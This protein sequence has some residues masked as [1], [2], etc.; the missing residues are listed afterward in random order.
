M[1]VN[2]EGEVLICDR[3]NKYLKMFN[4][5]GTF[6]MIIGQGLLKDPNRVCVLKQTN[7][8]LVN[9]NMMRCIKLFHKD[10]TFVCDFI[11]DLQ[12]PTAICENYKG[13]I[14]VTEYIS[15]QVLIYD[16]S[17][18]KLLHYFKSLLPAPAY[19]TAGPKGQMLVTDWRHHSFNTYQVNGDIMWKYYQ[20]CGELYFFFLTLIEGQHHDVLFS[21]FVYV[22]QIMVNASQLYLSVC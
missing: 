4:K 3:N 13:D 6:K 19:V 16:Q 20:K 12:Y 7:T 2:S 1:A 21:I 18:T 8:I 15:K 14:V 22:C 17:G 11:K 10:G 9:D 5:D